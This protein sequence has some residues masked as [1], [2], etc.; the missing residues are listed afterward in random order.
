[1]C[2][3]LGGGYMPR[4]LQSVVRASSNCTG[5]GARIPAKTFDCKLL[6]SPAE[7]SHG[8]KSIMPFIKLLWC[9]L[10]LNLIGRHRDESKSNFFCFLCNCKVSA[11]FQH[12]ISQDHYMRYKV[13]SIVIQLGQFADDREIILRHF[14]PI[15]LF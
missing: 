9:L 3:D 2:V 7:N 6:L 4:C 15:L 12:A 5:F 13:R 10:G 14:S 1:M 11:R 8:W